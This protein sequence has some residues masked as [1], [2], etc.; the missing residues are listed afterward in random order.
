[1][2]QR[3]PMLVA[4]LAA[5]ALTT[6]TALN[7]SRV[8]ADT[9]YLRATLVVALGMHAFTLLFRVFRVAIW[10]AIP[11]LAGALLVLLGIAYYRTTLNGPLPSGHTLLLLRTDLRAALSGFRT[12]VVPVPSASVY[13]VSAATALGVTAA[14]SDT[15]VFRAMGRIE[16]TLPSAVLFT[17][18]SALGTTQHRIA[19]TASWLSAAL[20]LVVTARHAH[21]R[22]A[23]VWMGGRRWTIAAALPSMVLSVALITA[24]ATYGGPHLPTARQAGLIEQRRASKSVTQVVSPLVDL[25][26]RLNRDQGIELFTVESSIGGHYWRLAGLPL[27]DGTTWSTSDEAL[28]DISD[29]RSPFVVTHNATA[30]IVVSQR[31]RIEN[32]RGHLVPAAAYPV[33][34]SPSQVM[35]APS[36]QGL[37]VPKV[38][39]QSG[40]V[41]VVRS[42][43]AEDVAGRLD[44]ATSNAPP[45]G[46]YLYVPTDLPADVSAIARQVTAAGTD[47]YHRLLL[48]QEWFRSQFA[49]DRT[50]QYGGGV[51]AIVDFLDA[52]KGFC[53]QFSAT[54][55]VMARTLGIPARVAV[56]FT[57]GVA[58][59]DGRFHVY[60]RHAHAWPE[61][62]FD[63]IGWVAFEPTPGRGNPDAASYTH[64][65]AAQDGSDI[66]TDT[67]STTSPPTTN[68]PTTTQAGRP[69]TTTSTNVG[70]DSSATSSTGSAP[71]IALGVF[72]VLA[73][74]CIAAPRLVEARLRR[75]HRTPDLQVR[76]AWRRTVR[77]LRAA[78]APDVGSRTPHEYATASATT[79]GIDA[80][81]LHELADAVTRCAYGP[82]AVEPDDAVECERTERRI[83][84]L[85]REHTP[86][87]RRIAE[88]VGPV[89]LWRAWRDEPAP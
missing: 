50:V 54:F 56:G 5:T 12:A 44:G 3:S 62:W 48:L 20:L 61:V 88:Q 81:P 73:A 65:T 25:R 37:V 29:P 6:V 39:L 59:A 85:C 28:V 74:W 11:L 76:A 24:A 41:I 69:T 75:R 87:R 33:F 16:A 89:S 53:Q 64:V 9:H 60:G 34:V 55:A 72:A 10:A 47:S 13:A 18:V 38:Q 31:I 52:R 4:T 66:P 35:L 30:E 49:Y 7:L 58:G 79:T 14:L 23:V 68:A 71:L 84:Q 46:P 17:A 36:S 22:S 42:A 15:F 78:G 8:F 2:M 80:Q 70:G 19:L 27:F 67:V 77:A 40:D 26:N 57:P 21:A 1:M 43:I 82:N 45:K 51:N 83:R 86:T 63:G 32:L